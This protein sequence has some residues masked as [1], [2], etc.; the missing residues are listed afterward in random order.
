MAESE[1]ADESCAEPLKK[2]TTQTQK[3]VA[4]KFSYESEKDWEK[5]NIWNLL[6]LEQFCIRMDY[7]VFD[8]VKI[9]LIGFKKLRHK[10]NQ[11]M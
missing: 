5:D 7:L 11:G 3:L 2:A 6:G 4:A 9:M 1:S 10:G 8:Y